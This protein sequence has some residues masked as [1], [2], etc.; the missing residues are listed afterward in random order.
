MRE[1]TSRGA[2]SPVLRIG[3]QGAG[4]TRSHTEIRGCAAGAWQHLRLISV[5]PGQAQVLSRCCRHLTVFSTCLLLLGCDLVTAPENAVPP[6]LETDGTSFRLAEWNGWY[7]VD[8]PYT[9]TNRT[10]G[11]VYFVNC[12]RTI[13]T[14]LERRERR[15]VWREAWRTINPLCLSRPIVIQ[16]DSASRHIL[17]LIVPAPDSKWADRFHKLDPPGTYR[18]VLEDAISSD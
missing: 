17:W 11:D 4:P 8:I 6:G 16:P 7:M 15:G 3:P 14:R 2:I 18:I 12:G 1:D 10:G 9:F 13:T 5:G